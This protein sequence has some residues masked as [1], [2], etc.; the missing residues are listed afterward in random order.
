MKIQNSK[1]PADDIRSM[2][3]T[4]RNFSTSTRGNLREQPEVPGQEMTQPSAQPDKGPENEDMLVINNVE[5]EIRSDDNQDLS[6]KDDE[7]GI[8]SQ[9]IDDFKKEV[10]EL[11]DFGKLQI[12]S[13]S[14]KLDGKI[15]QKGIEFT[16]STGDDNGIYLSNASMLKIDDET[17][18]YL[19]KLKSFEEKFSGSIND[20][21]VNRKNN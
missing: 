6:I 8:I 21:I 10:S 16:L 17:M 1:K 19:E 20:L 14:A 3:N 13:D 15:T 11:V 18:E 9:L 5:V 12:Y 2:L 4:I 7:K